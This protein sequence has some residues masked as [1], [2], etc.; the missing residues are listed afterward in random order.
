M[1]MLWIT[2][3]KAPKKVYPDT[4]FSI[5]WR[6]WYLGWPFKTIY[7]CL[8]DE[9]DHVLMEWYHKMWWFWGKVSKIVEISGIN[10]DSM[11]YIHAGYK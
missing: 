7:T 2:K 8:A 4:S 9:D 5:Y 11:F 10:K 1:R 6:V 3:V